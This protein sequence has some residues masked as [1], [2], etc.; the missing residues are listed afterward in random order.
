MTASALGN[1][2]L[3]LKAL[4]TVLTD[5]NEFANELYATF[6]PAF[7]HF[8][9]TKALYTRLDTIMEKNTNFP[10]WKMLVSDSQLEENVREALLDQM[11][12]VPT[13]QAK[14][15]FEY[16]TQELAELARKRL[17]YNSLLTTQESLYDISKLSTDIASEVSASLLSLN[18]DDPNSELAMGMG[19]NILGEQIFNDIVYNTES[20]NVIKTGYKSFDDR[21][22]G[23]QR[24]NLVLIGANSGGGKSQMAVNLMIRQYLMGYTVVLASYEMNYHEIMTRVL[25]ILSEVPMELISNKTMTPHQKKVVEYTWRKFILFGLKNNNTFYITT[26]SGETTITEICVRY[27]SKK[28]TSIIFDYI[29]LL[30]SKSKHSEAQWQ[31]LGEISKEGKVMAK[32][33]DC[34]VFLLV[35]IDDQLQLRYSKAIKDH[36]NWFMGWIYDDEARANGF[37]TVKQLKARNAPCYDFPL[38]TRFDISQFRDPD[39]VDKIIQFTDAEF[40]DLLVESKDAGAMLK[41]DLPL[42]I[43]EEPTVLKLVEKEEEEV[44]K[45]DDTVQLDPAPEFEPELTLADVKRTSEVISFYEKPVDFDD[46]I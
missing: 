10:T 5:G 30:T 8:K 29:N 31:M 39:E 38:I 19:Y 37:V 34:V 22:G 41:L 36:A 14:G 28:P 32:K 42:E 2:E 44:L 23:H 11:D 46:L 21:S 12:R 6:K 17:I 24:G 13:V 1:L 7:F 18:N 16:L 26:P 45:I 4:K 40:T 3:E 15:D 35:Q 9:V 33:M 43:L 20:K 27:K 25:S